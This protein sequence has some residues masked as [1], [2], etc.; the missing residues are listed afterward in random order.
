MAGYPYKLEDSSIHTF[1]IK[2]EIAIKKLAV[3]EI[4]KAEKEREMAKHEQSK[5]GVN[6]HKRMAEGEKIE[7]KAGGMAKKEKPKAKHKKK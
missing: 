4:N 6:R 1:T 2:E 7:L 3:E 5:S